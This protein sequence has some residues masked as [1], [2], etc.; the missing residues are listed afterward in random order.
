MHSFLPLHSAVKYVILICAHLCTYLFTSVLHSPMHSILHSICAPVCT[1]IY[2]PICTPICAPFALQFTLHFALFLA[3]YYALVFKCRSILHSILRSILHSNLRYI[4]HS[5]KRSN[6]ALIFITFA[7]FYCIQ[8]C[9]QVFILIC[10][11]LSLI[12]SLLFCSLPMH[13]ILHS[14]CA[15]FALQFT[16]PL[17]F[18]LLSI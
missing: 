14:V 4:L 13:S 10:A 9:T 8:F 16:P 15:P 6:Y 1:P 7:L 17:H 12:S 18:N 11:R 2:A 5:F 3:L